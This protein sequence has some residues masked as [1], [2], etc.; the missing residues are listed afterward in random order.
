MDVDEE[1]AQV[2][3]AHHHRGVEPLSTQEDE[4][5]P[6]SVSSCALYGHTDSVMAIDIA[7]GCEM[8][9]SGSVDGTVRLWSPEL[10]TGLVSFRYS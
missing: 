7:P 1:A 10:Q 6:S 5:A 9:L 3:T 4:P 8:V 2:P